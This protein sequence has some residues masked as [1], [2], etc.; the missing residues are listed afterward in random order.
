MSNPISPLLFGYPK[1]GN[2][3]RRLLLVFGLDRHAFLFDRSGP[4]A[5]LFS[6]SFLRCG[7]S[8]WK[9]LVGPWVVTDEKASFLPLPDAPGRGITVTLSSYGKTVKRVFPFTRRN[10]DSGALVPSRSSL[11]F[12]FSD[13]HKVRIT[14]KVTATSF[15]S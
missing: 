15:F 6:D 13:L 3:W 14:S 2:T 7:F 5:S 11:F 10:T 9:R 4:E 8:R 12:F 1:A